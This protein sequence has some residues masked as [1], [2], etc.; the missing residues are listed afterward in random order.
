[1]VSALSCLQI[2]WERYSALQ[3]SLILVWVMCLLKLDINLRCV[4]LHDTD[5][6][7]RQQVCPWGLSSSL[8]HVMGNSK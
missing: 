1:M 6:P 8:S 2:T 7:Q 5:L 3:D 4:I